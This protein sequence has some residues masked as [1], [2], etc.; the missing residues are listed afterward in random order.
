MRSDFSYWYL[1][2][3]TIA[4]IKAIETYVRPSP[5]GGLLMAF[6]DAMTAVVVFVTFSS[7]LIGDLLRFRVVA[8]QAN[9]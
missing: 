5:G 7:I 2:C 1:M 9:R 8:P 3:V 4:A 6:A